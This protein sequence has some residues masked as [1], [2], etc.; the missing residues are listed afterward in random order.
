M[1]GV[2]LALF[3]GNTLLGWVGSFY[4]EMTP[5]EFWTLDSAIGLGGVLVGLVFLRPMRRALADDPA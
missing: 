5:A 4:G 1:G 2:F 3:L